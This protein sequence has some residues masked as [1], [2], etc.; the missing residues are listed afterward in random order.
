VWAR[1]S[2]YNF[3]PRAGSSC[4][5]SW[6]FFLIFIKT[7]FLKKQILTRVKKYL[8]KKKKTTPKA[9]GSFLKGFP[10]L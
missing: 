6:D 8:E 5:D 7:F 10:F 2:A 4:P 9:L 3:S 1:V